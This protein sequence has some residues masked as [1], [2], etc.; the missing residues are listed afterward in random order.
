MSYVCLQCVNEPRSHSFD[1]LKETSDGIVV[2]YTCPAKA[3]YY[4]DYHGIMLHYDGML[5]SNGDTQWI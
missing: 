2:F 1:K 3:K 5:K 4:N